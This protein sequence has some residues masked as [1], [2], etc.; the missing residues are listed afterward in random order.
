MLFWEIYP[1][2]PAKVRGFKRI[3]DEQD[4]TITKVTH[5]LNNSGFVTALELEVKLSDVEYDADAD[6]E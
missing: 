1:E 6:I 2:T 3:I 5:S 4:W